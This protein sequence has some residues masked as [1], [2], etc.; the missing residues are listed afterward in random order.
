MVTLSSKDTLASLDDSVTITAY[1]T[2]NLPAPY[3]SSARYVRDMLEEFRAASK[4][5]VSFEFIDPAAQETEKDKEQKKEVKRDIFGR[6]FREQTQ[7]E[8]DL[9]SQGIQPVEIRV[10]E[11]DQQQTKRA[12]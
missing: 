5:K 11:S 4:G 10:V 9:A 7:Q 1:F 6:Q 12:Y 8:K 3:S 2:E